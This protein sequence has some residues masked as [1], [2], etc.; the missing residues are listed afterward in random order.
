MPD[1]PEYTLACELT[2]TLHAAMNRHGGDSPEAEACRDAFDDAKGRSIH[3]R[4]TGEEQTRLS[5]YSEALYAAAE[6]EA[7]RTGVPVRD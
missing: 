3:R 7:V 2:A 1:R 5:A 4:L 6:A